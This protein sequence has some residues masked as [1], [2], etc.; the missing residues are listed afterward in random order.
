MASGGHGHETLK[1]GKFRGHA[2]AVVPNSYLRYLLTQDWF[3]DHDQFEAV[4]DEMAWRRDNNV[5]VEE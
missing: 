5:H 1:F 2:L 4:Q 3:E